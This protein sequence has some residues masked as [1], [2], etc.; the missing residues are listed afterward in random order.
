MSLYN[1]EIDR[2]ANDSENEKENVEKLFSKSDNER[3]LI[4]SEKSSTS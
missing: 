4:G 3:K 1:S 2:L